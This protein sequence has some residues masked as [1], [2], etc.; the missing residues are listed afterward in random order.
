MSEANRSTAGRWE[1]DPHAWVEEQL[2]RKAQDGTVARH[3]RRDGVSY[4]E[5][6]ISLAEELDRPFKEIRTKYARRRAERAIEL[7]EG[8]L[9]IQVR[10]YAEKHNTSYPVALEAVL[11]STPGGKGPVELGETRLPVDDGDAA[12]NRR[13][14]S[15]AARHGVTFSAALTA[16]L[17][18]QDA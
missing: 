10:S 18:G 2:E 5:A 14:E 8:D 15:Y 17:E 1:I 3:A 11:G 7:D 13:A 16:V 6:M 9:D 12:I 4:A